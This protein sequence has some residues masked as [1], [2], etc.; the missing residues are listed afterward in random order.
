MDPLAIANIFASKQTG[1]KGYSIFDVLDEYLK[2]L[3]KID[4]IQ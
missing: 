1:L 3:H 2:D 4:G